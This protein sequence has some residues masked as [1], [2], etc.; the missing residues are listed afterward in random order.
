VARSKIAETAERHRQSKAAWAHRAGEE[1]RRGRVG[2]PGRPKDVARKNRG[3]DSLESFALDYFPRRFYLPFSADHRKVIERLERCTNDGGLFCCAMPRGTGKSALA[4]VAVLR[5]VLYGLRRF[6]LL[7][8][9][10]ERHASRAL[11]RLQAE[12]ETNALLHEDFPEATLPIR[13]LERIARRIQGQVW[14]DGTPT[15]IEWTA[16][17]ITLATWPDSACSGAVVHVA[18]LSAALRGQMILG[19]GGEPIRPDLVVLDDVQT[20]DSAKSPTQT[21]DREAIVQDDVLLM[22]GPTTRMAAVNLCTVIYPNDLSDRFLD[23]ERHPEWQ[24]VRTKLLLSFPKRVDLWDEY[25][26]ARKL[27]QAEGDGGRRADDLYAARRAEMDEGGAVSWPERKKPGE[28][29]GL[30]SAMNA[31]YENPRGFHSEY[32]NDPQ[33]DALAAGAKEY[34]AQTLA[35][36]LSGTERYQVPREATRLTAGID[37]GGNIHWYCVVAWTEQGGGTVIDY[38]CHPAQNRPMF[39]A[40]D[41][42]PSLVDVYPG[43]TESQLVFA[44]LRDLTADVLGRTYYRDGGGEVRAERALVDSGWQAQAVYQFVRA[45]GHQGVLL[46]SKG[47]GRTTTAR[48]VGEW[49]PRPGERVGFH[50][51]LSLPERGSG[52]TLLFDPDPYKSLLF[53]RLTTPPGGGTALTLFG[54]STAAHALIAEHLAA[55]YATPATLRGI[56]FDKWTPLPDRP[57]NHLLDCLVLAAVAASLAGLQWSAAGQPAAPRAPR[58]RTVS[59]AELQRARK[60]LAGR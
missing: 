51:R 4:E 3:L 31:Y 60:A 15:R 19:P 53:E 7:V 26:A 50:W 13:A 43:H 42:R 59:L 24:G 21:T 58:R 56:T 25:A 39:E 41:A 6:V 9:A 48:G 5:A 23:P 47:V 30:Q 36:R 37:C 1:A 16:E 12:L 54:R 22:A 32:Q 33:A 17:G 57:D 10:T 45:G 14:G 44:G 27:G 11:K 20:R 49:K 38:G 46:P 8:N 35:A 52:R 18:G 55:E 2:V 28:L 34:N 40:R 29:S